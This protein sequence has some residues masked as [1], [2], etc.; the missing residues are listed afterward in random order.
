MPALDIPLQLT[1]VYKTKIWGRR[2][3]EP[4]FPI[5]KDLSVLDEPIGEVWITDDASQFRNGPFA[6]MTLRDAVA[7]FGGE[8]CGSAW[9]E[10]RF[11]LLAKYI[12]T[13]EWLSVQVHPDDD[14]ARVHDPGSP[15]KTEMW[16]IVRAHRGAEF[17][18]GL[19]PGVRKDAL[20]AACQKG[21]ASDLLEL[22]HARTG[23]AIYVPPGTVHALGPELVLFEVEQNSDITYRLDDYGR[24]GADGKPRPLHLEKGLT[25]IQPELPAYRNLPRVVLREP[26]GQRR[27][28]LASRHFA[29]EELTLKKLAKLAGNPRRVEVLSFLEGEGRVEIAVGWMGFRSGDTWLIPPGA[30]A[31]RIVPTEETRLLKFYVPDLEHDIRRPLARRVP[32]RELNSIVFD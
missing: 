25:V 5:P 19:K 24:V 20:C 2:D 12:F 17:L 6:G 8:L 9:P 10:R 31:F 30:R 16:Y 7:K 3:L 26:Y 32:S 13:S 15:G 28:V 4:L 27:L 1:P 14:Y 11:P 23:E 21:T 18:L 22:F 29:L